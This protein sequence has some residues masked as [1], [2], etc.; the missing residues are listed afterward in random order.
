M[1]IKKGEPWGEPATPP[2]DAISTSTD[3]DISRALEQARRDDVAFPSFVITG[4]DLGRTL[5][6]SGNPARA[7]P[8]D[9]GEVLVDGRHHYFVAHIV[10]RTRNWRSF[11]VAM[12][13]QW[14]GEW[15]LGPKAHPN[16]GI[17]DGY[18]ATLGYFDW[19]KVRDR[20]PTGSHLPHP[21]ID[22]TRRRAI[23]FEFAK[24]RPVF[25]DGE[26]VADAKHVAARLT[27]DALTVYA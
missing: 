3:R 13:A 1:T 16:D 26:H 15:N 18:E 9:L 8:L 4:G 17:L 11:A 21:R 2:P 7:Y 6:A 14:V 20:L 25:V 19:R 12:N 22:V 10:A 5:A 24:A 27:P 23:S